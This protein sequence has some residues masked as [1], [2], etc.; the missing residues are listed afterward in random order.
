MSLTYSALPL[1]NP[2]LINLDTDPKEPEL[3]DY[4]Y[5]HPRVGAQVAKIL[6]DYKE[7]TK[8]GPLIPGGAPL[9]YLPRGK[10]P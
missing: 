6:Q 10:Q 7:S 5:L 8:R 4:P 9:H 3:V 2:H 1:P